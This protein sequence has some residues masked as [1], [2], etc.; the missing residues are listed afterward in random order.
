MRKLLKKLILI[1]VVFTGLGIVV[2]TLE[3]LR[4]K[5]GW[6]PNHK[7][8]V[9][10]EKYIKRPLDFGL[11]LFVLIILS[12]VMLITALFVKLKFG[13]P[14]LFS[15]ERPGLGEKSF[16]LLKFRTM[17]QEKDSSG[18]LLPDEARLTSFGKVL[19]STSIDELPELLNILCGDMSMIGP[20]PLLVGYLPY[21]TAGQ[22]HRHDVRPGLTGYAQA[23]GR[24]TVDW[25]DKFKMDVKYCNNITFRSDVKIIFDTVRTV[26]KH[27]G[28]SSKTSATMESFVDY[29]VKI[30]RSNPSCDNSKG[31][32][33]R[34]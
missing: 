14:V 24:N 20:R 28:I 17:T 11:S 29:C 26:L 15:Q 13:S 34:K 30:G 32:P 16:Q 19:R 8:K 10:Y 21:Y 33:F 9:P 4:G 18:T 23:H 25:D 12:P 7:P 1:L 5:V 2:G 3:R 22:R 31:K 27:E 6:V